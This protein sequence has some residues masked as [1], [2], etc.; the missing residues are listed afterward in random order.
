MMEWEESTMTLEEEVKENEVALTEETARIDALEDKEEDI[1]DCE[2]DPGVSNGDWDTFEQAKA[3]FAAHLNS[4]K[5]AR[6]EA[7]LAEERLRVAAIQ[8]KIRQIKNKNFNG[9]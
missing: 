7:K 3:M 9:N 8:E 6:D 2:R 1:C 5:Q 4:L